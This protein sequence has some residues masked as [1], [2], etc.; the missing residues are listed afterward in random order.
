MCVTGKFC[1]VLLPENSI[2]EEITFNCLDY[3]LASEDLLGRENISII[4]HTGIK[5]NGF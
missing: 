2:G 4:I 1:P 3:I 5:L